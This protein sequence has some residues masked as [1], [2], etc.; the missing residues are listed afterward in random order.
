MPTVVHTDAILASAFCQVYAQDGPTAEPVMRHQICPCIRGGCCGP[1]PG[2]SQ[3][4][5]PELDSRVALFWSLSSSLQYCVAPLLTE[6]IY[7][8]ESTI[9]CDRFVA[10]IQRFL[11]CFSVIPSTT[12]FIPFS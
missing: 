9:A 6:M 8:A 12:S 10:Y 4:H 2:T 3:Q 1:E 5:G 7:A 11:S